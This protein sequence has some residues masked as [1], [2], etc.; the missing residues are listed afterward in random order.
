[1]TPLGL[2]VL[3]QK[4]FQSPLA[5]KRSHIFFSICAKPTSRFL[6][7]YLHL[8]LIASE[9]TKAD[10]KDRL[11]EVTNDLPNEYDR[12]LA[13]IQQSSARSKLATRVFTWLL[14]VKTLLRSA[15]LCE[16]LAIGFEDNSLQRDR[17]PKIS[18]V[19]DACQGLV[20][21]NQ[22]SDTVEFFH[23][24]VKEHII[25][26][27][28]Q[29]PSAVDIP[30][31][32]L[33]YLRFNDF[34]TPCS[35][36]FGVEVRRKQYPFSSYVSQFWP[37]HVRDAPEE[38]LYF[39]ILDLLTS[40]KIF[41]AIQLIPSAVR[42]SRLIG[43]EED[44][45]QCTQPEKPLAVYLC[46]CL[47]L[48][49]TLERLLKENTI[50][51]LRVPW[52]EEYS[53]LHV[54]VCSGDSEMLDMLL[55]AGGDPNIPDKWGLTPLHLAAR[56][57]SCTEFDLI[58]RLVRASPKLD[59]LDQDRRT[60]LHIAVRHATLESVQ[61]LLDAGFDGNIQ[62]KDG[63]TPLHYAVERGSLGIV[64]AL[65]VKYANPTIANNNDQNALALSLSNNNH[66]ITDA[67]LKSTNENGSPYEFSE[68]DRE[69][70]HGFLAKYADCLEIEKQVVLETERATAEM[71]QSQRTLHCNATISEVFWAA[72]KG[73]Y[74]RLQE[75]MRE[76]ANVNRINPFTGQTALHLA[77]INR[78][79]ETALYLL[80]SG[81][82]ESIKD[83][84][85]KTAREYCPGLLEP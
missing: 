64:S 59:I 20:R 32:C 48:K 38:S 61:L 15:E 80:D 70:A 75:L 7:A 44:Y 76:G 8:D 83:C 69:A 55:Q 77:V 57:Q 25:L 54:A 28:M 39:L 49:K 40:S 14:N 22:S 1:V 19:L 60:V 4:L 3:P 11:K 42:N 74:G 37:E 30:R 52:G 27:E 56:L 10:I 47:E 85:G 79:R 43:R 13:R 53:P 31:Y 68:L 23:F 35:D 36:K 26:R 6:L 18:I 16:A 81:A 67:L 12:N 21:I 29:A 66:I 72:E 9:S 84:N 50:P 63:Q 71:K 46:A 73:A 45:S 2:V 65:L 58:H 41:S 78:R 82:D 34:F 33:K 51:N 17:K 5:S 62:D 24:S